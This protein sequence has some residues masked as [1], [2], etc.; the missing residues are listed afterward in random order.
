MS[1]AWAYAGGLLMVAATVPQVVRLARTRDASSFTWGFTLLNFVGISLLVM[2]SWEI[3]E[4]AFVIL[5]VTTASFWLMVAALKV[6]GAST[7]APQPKLQ[8]AEP[9]TQ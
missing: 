7:G 9:E 2:R 8:T 4:T 1:E 6:L 5:N 3:R